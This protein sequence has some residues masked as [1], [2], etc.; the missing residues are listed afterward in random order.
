M[1]EL[2]EEQMPSW[3]NHLLPATMLALVLMGL[4]GA[5]R[6]SLSDCEKQGLV[7]RLD[8]SAPKV[9]CESPKASAE[10]AKPAR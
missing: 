6:Q 7:G 2:R 3:T 8:W 10:G 4:V 1:D 9:V 5:A